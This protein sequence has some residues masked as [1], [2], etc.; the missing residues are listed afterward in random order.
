MWLLNI[1]SFKLEVFQGSDV[2]AYV[3]LSHTWAAGELSFEDVCNGLQP[4]A[5]QKA[6]WAKVQHCCTQ[7]AADG[8]HYFWVDTCCS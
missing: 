6:G 7:A 5:T 4:S 1:Q 2:P 8:Y 3:I